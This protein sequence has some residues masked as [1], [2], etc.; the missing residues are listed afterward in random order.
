MVWIQTILISITLLGG[1]ANYDFSALGENFLFMA[2]NK[3]VSNSRGY[4]LYIYTHMGEV[5]RH[6]GME[7]SDLGTL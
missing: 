2:V 7:P 1:P 4:V 3:R 5:A 6:A